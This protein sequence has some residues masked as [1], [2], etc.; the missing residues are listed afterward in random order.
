M[1]KGIALTK[2]NGSILGPIAILL[3]LIIDTLFNILSGI[4]LPNIGLAIILFTII[5]YLLMLPLTF[6]Q[7]KF[8]KMSAVMNPEIRA[9]Q[10][11]YKGKTDSQSMQMQNEE[12]QKVYKKYGVS[13]AGSCI[14]LLIQMP[15][16]FA[17][18]RV[19][20]N[21][22]AYVTKVFDS[23]SP[24]AEKIISTPG[25]IDAVKGLDTATKYF[26]ADNLDYSKVNTIIDVLNRATSKEWT[27]LKDSIPSIGDVLTKAQE[28]FYSFNNFLGLNISESPNEIFSNAWNVQ[29]YALVIGALMVPVLAALSQWL[30]VLF[31]PQP[32]KN[33]DNPMAASMKSMNLIMP[34][35]SAVFCFTLPAGLGIYWISS[36]VVRCFQQV[37]INK[38]FDKIGLDKIIEQN[39]ERAK[40]KEEKVKKLTSTTTSSGLDKKKL[41]NVK[42]LPSAD[43]TGKTFKKGSLA[44]RANMVSRLNE[45]NK[46]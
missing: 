23:L 46:E 15:I 38:H 32:A 9:V 31:M 20:Y 1:Y 45:K 27:L 25:G 7:Q 21:I 4:G 40:K 6:K 34:I 24:L 30:N 35:M 39:I 44:E 37:A 17:L 19:M 22:P 36:A 33:D 8:A 11:K 43:N 3:G 29:N 2:Y 18:Y 12:L 5:I 42:N 41:N 16:L 26:A 10:E 13:P 28:S 14:Q